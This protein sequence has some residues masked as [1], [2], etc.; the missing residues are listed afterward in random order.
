SILHDP[1]TTLIY[2][3][4]LH[5]ALPISWHNNIVTSLFW[6]GANGNTRSAWDAEWVAHYGGVDNP[7]PSA[8]RDYIPV[9]F[10]PR[11]NPFYCALPYNDLMREQFRP[12][13]ALV[14]P[15]FKSAYLG[16]GQSV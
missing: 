11:Q 13:A 5:D 1:P 7:K 15:W 10:I 12:E 16:P 8:R 2:T 14:I 6:I 3:L 4:S 9:R